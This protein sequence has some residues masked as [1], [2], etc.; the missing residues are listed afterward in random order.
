MWEHT[1]GA[2]GPERTMQHMTDAGMWLTQRGKESAAQIAREVL[3][4]LYWPEEREA[5]A[6]RRGRKLLGEDKWAPT[7][8]GVAKSC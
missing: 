5:G 6:A 7:L 4:D 1:S 3:A 2:L 8:R